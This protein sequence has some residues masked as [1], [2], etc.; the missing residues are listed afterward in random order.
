MFE[1]IKYI[2]IDCSNYNEKEKYENIE[3]FF[4]NFL[5]EKE[6]INKPKKFI[7]WYIWTKYENAEILYNNIEDK[8][9]LIKGNWSKE[10]IITENNLIILFKNIIKIEAHFIEKKNG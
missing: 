3:A 6:L 4:R 9:L 5:W 1:G 10:N 8:Y 7:I 2:G